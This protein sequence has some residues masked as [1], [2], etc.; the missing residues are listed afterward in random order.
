MSRLRTAILALAMLVTLVAADAFA[1]SRVSRSLNYLQVFGGFAKPVYRSRIARRFI[2][3]P[4]CNIY[5]TSIDL[6]SAFL[7]LLPLLDPCRSS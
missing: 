5:T 6:L 3:I 4:T 7:K 1:I 2:M